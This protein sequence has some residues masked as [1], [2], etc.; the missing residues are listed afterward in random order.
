MTEAEELFEHA[1]KAMQEAADG[2][3][4]EA[5]RT[6]WSRRCLGR[7]RRPPNPGRSIAAGRQVAQEK[8]VTCHERFREFQPRAAYISISPAQRFSASSLRWR[9]FLAFGRCANVKES[10]I[11]YPC[12]YGSTP[13]AL[14]IIYHDSSA[15]VPPDVHQGTATYIFRNR[16]PIKIKIAFPPISCVNSCEVPFARD[17]SPLMPSFCRKPQL[18]ELPPNGEVRFKAGYTILV[19]LLASGYSCLGIPTDRRTKLSYRP[20]SKAPVSSLARLS[21]CPNGA[22]IELS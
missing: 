20:R 12:V 8:T 3:V 13:V 16:L 9:F 10:W 6:T 22:M 1:E 18:V 14:H 15:S 2:V 17:N 19:T 11:L 5:R 4:E 7:R 21:F